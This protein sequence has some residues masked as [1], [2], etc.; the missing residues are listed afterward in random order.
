MREEK[1]IIFDHHGYYFIELLVLLLGIF[2]MFLFHTD[3]GL[4]F[5]ILAF[6]LFSYMT[7]GLVHHH[8]NHTLKLKI[9][10]EYVLI[11]ALIL[12]AFIMLNIGRI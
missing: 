10:L 7:L 6:I 3:V 12:V 4:Q 9:V 11:S 2:L 8:I 5:L 1:D